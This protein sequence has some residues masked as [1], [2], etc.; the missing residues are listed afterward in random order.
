MGK[1]WRWIP[2]LYFAEGLPYVVVMTLS[3]IMYKRLGLSNSEVALYT[4]WLYLPWVIKPFW[5]PLVDL[6]KSKR[7]WIVTMQLLIGA[8]FAG[9]ALALPTPHF[10]RLTLA[11]LWLVAFSSAT[12]DISA[13]G[14]Y[15]LALKPHQQSF[16]VGIRSTFYRIATVVGQGV[17]VMGAGYLEKRSGNIALAWSAIFLLLALL[18]LLFSLLH[19]R[20]LPTP[21]K[22]SE[23]LSS[24]EIEGDRTNKSSGIGSVFRGYIEVLSSYFKKEGIVPALLFLLF[25]RFSEAQL[26]KMVSPFLLDSREVG[27]LGLSTQMVG[28]AYGT[29]GIIALT[30]GGIV[31]GM[32]VSVGGFKRWLWPMA[33]S[34]S[35][36]SFAFVYLATV[37]PTS[38]FIIN[39]SIFVEQLGYGFGFT[40]YML[41][42]LYFSQGR[43]ESAHYAISTAFMALGMMLPGM[44]AG[45]LQEMMGYKLFFWWI[46]GGFIL[47]F[48]VTASIKIDP[49]FGKKE[50]KLSNT[51]GS[52]NEPSSSNNKKNSL[53]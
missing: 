29:V 2:S 35:L 12:H 43:Y 19:K 26:V 46:M 23:H 52:Q 42:M 15:I 38:L 6:L 9:V 16:F 17:L 7:W 14:F 8:G 39:L 47:T 33:L 4:G 18:F 21:L 45:V 50:R 25:Y 53:S 3:V 27:G 34:I 20:V 10:V 37:Q 30:I 44:A 28:V 1:H 41:F 36:P 48:L 49:N 51:P 5:S 31:G 22:D 32:V 13:D 24:V 40:A 11:A